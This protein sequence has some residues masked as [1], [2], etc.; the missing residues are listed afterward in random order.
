MRIVVQTVPLLE[1]RYSTLGDYWV[2]GDGTVQVRVTEM[3]DEYHEMLCAVHEVIEFFLCKRRG[4]PEPDIM[5][6]DLAHP[7][8]PEPGEHPDAPYRK[9]HAFAEHIEYLIARQMNIP[10]DVY[11]AAAEKVFE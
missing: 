11:E 5:A 6:F 2:D 4:I 9:E 8:L 7:E 3:G 10:W 1:Q